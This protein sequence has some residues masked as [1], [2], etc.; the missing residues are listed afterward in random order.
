MCYD[1]SES[2][3]DEIEAD[4][5]SEGLNEDHCEECGECDGDGECADPDFDGDG[6]DEGD[7]DD[8]DDYAYDDFVDGD[9]ELIDGVGFADPGGTWSTPLELR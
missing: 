8:G 3:R 9:D 2:L 1:D 6:G 5:Q 7:F 4:M